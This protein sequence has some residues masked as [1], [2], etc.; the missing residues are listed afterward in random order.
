[1][2]KFAILGALLGVL[3]TTVGD[4]AAG[5]VLFGAAGAT[6]AWG[7]RKIITPLV[8]LS[9]LLEGLPA[10]M[11]DRTAWE[12]K[13][14]DWHVEERMTALEEK[15]NEAAAKA[16]VAAGQADVAA[17][18]AKESVNVVRAVARQVGATVR[19]DPDDD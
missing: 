4:V 14:D 8:N 11:K 6:L 3:A 2:L 1:M 17:T 7:W 12:E 18:R 5:V 10:W 19:G 13:V 16:D 9:T 15:A